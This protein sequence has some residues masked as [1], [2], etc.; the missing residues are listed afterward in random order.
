MKRKWSR[1]E[2]LV[3]L[4]PIL[5]LGFYVGNSVYSRNVFRHPKYLLSVAYSPDGKTIATGCGDDQM[6]V[7][8]VE[9]GTIDSTFEGNSENGVS[10]AFSPD[11]NLIAGAFGTGL[12]Q[13]PMGPDPIPN[14]LRVWDIKTKSLIW[15]LKGNTHEA[16]AVVFSPD[17]Q[18]L[19]GGGDQIKLWDMKSGQLL[20]TIGPVGYSLWKV[21]FSLDGKT[22][23]GGDF[24]GKVKIWDVQT[25]RQLKTFNYSKHWVRAVAFSPDGTLVAGAG[26]DS[27]PAKNGNPEER[28]YTIKIWE[29]KSGKERR[30]MHSL[31]NNIRTLAFS[32]DGHTLASG[33]YGNAVRIWDI[34]N[35]TLLR[36]LQHRDAVGAIAFSPDGKKLA[37]A[38]DDGKVIMWD[39]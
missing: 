1:S 12:T 27:V 11:G 26:D 30:V 19:A 23:A 24:E 5:L 28:E 6:R 9:T 31:G 8:N 37:A 7:W 18:L 2:K 15:T 4:A 33:G 22:I 34:E 21:V 16:G 14:D 13:N 10:V 35:G 20:R 38:S 29:V 25:G 39:M 32:P 36:T 3:F 17:S